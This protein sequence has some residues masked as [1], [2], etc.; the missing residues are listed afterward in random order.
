M[1]IIG[2]KLKFF[3]L[4]ACSCTHANQVPEDLIFTLFTV[5]ILLNHVVEDFI[6]FQALAKTFPE[7]TDDHV[8]N[9]VTAMMNAVQI[10]FDDEALGHRITLVIKR[11]EVLK[12]QNPKDLPPIDDIEKMLDR[13]CKVSIFGC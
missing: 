2:S 12:H 13:F 1:K 8:V 3:K 11:L 7:N 4:C 10:L 6:L 5:L 9:V